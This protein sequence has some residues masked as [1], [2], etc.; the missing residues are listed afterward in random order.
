[1]MNARLTS[2]AISKIRRFGV[3]SVL[4]RS[5]ETTKP[6]EKHQ[7]SQKH[8]VDKNASSEIFIQCISSDV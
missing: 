2:F 4:V 8:L 3:S 5:N 7:N 1:M 6:N